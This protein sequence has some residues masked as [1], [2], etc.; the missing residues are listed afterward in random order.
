M[1]SMKPVQ[2]PNPNPSHATYNYRYRCKTWYGHSV[3]I[4]NLSV[5]PDVPTDQVRTIARKDARDFTGYPE[6]SVE[7]L[8]RFFVT[9]H[10]DRAYPSLL[11]FPTAAFES[12]NKP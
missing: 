12:H 7:L 3:G 10:M 4:R 8:H 6:C 9:I 2:P 5:P 1:N 11:Q